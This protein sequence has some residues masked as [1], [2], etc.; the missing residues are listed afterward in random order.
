MNKLKLLAGALILAAG[1][2]AAAQSGSGYYQDQAGFSDRIERLSQQLESDLRTGRVDRNQV[3]SLRQEIS[4]LRQIERQYR[5]A[6][7]NRYERDDLSRRLMAVRERIRLASRGSDY[8][9][10]EDRDDYRA[11]RYRRGDRYDDDRTDRYRRGDRYDDDRVDN[12][13]DYRGQ[14]GRRGSDEWDRRGEWDERNRWS[15]RDCPPG[16]AKRNNGC[17]PPG[18]VGRGDARGYE[19]S[20]DGYYAVPERYRYQYR[21]TNR[22]YHR[23]R[24]GYVFRIDRRTGRTIDTIYV[25]R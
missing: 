23:Y 18:Q 11:D 9:G 2:P 16:L 7:F 22:L 19:Q 17:V 14:Y 5:V 20:T 21:D 25:G 13:D 1:A 10:Y 6:G 3:Y 15:D 4:S 8:R 24:D 12:D